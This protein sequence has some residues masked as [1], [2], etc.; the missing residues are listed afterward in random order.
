MGPGFL[1]AIICWGTLHFTADQNSVLRLC[2][3]FKGD[4]V[5]DNSAISWWTITSVLLV[6]I[7]LETLVGILIKKD[8]REWGNSNCTKYQGG[9]QC[10]HAM[11]YKT[12]TY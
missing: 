7:K 5:A 12:K 2:C 4:G 11:F 8:L 6:H 1:A 10:D 9:W 3:Y